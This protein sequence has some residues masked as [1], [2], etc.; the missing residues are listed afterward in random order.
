MTFEPEFSRPISVEGITPDKERT[1][2]L[3]ANAKEC[4]ALAERFDLRSLSD[5]KTVM[6]LRRVGGGTLRVE[7]ILSADVVQ[8]C[9]VS[10]QEVHAHIDGKFETYF[11]EESLDLPEEIDLM[12]DDGESSPEMITNGHVDLGEVAAQYLSLNLD[13]Y[14]RAPGVSLAAQLAEIGGEVR[15]SPFEMLQAAAEQQALMPS[16]EE[17][18]PNRI[19]IIPRREKEPRMPKPRLTAVPAPEASVALMAK[20]LQPTESRMARLKWYPPI[21]PVH[22]AAL[23]SV[24]ANNPAA[25]AAE[26]KAAK[27]SAPKKAAEKKPAAKKSAAKKSAAKKPVAKKAPAKTA[28]KAG[29]KKAAKKTAKKAVKKAVKKVAKKA[30]K[31]PLPKKAKATA[32]KA[33][34]RKAPAKKLA[35]KPAKKMAKKTAK[36]TAVKTVKKAV[37]KAATK[38][39]KKKTKAR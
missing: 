1:E 30:V 15:N 35:R 7:G 22:E 10:L 24:A 29:V 26:V 9:V 37:K 11:T 3:E 36:K 17:G 5:F 6:K 8:T 33:A 20:V 4:A 14:P 38:K 32:K 13:P 39:L 16:V 28:K 2:T 18:G 19:K 21:A 12:L 25:P 27:K 31:K 34:A 23:A